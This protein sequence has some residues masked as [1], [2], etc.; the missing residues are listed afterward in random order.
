MASAQVY[1]P[2]KS[3][4]PMTTSLDDLMDR[5]PIEARRLLDRNI[6]ADISVKDAQTWL[7]FFTQGADPVAKGLST[8]LAHWL[9]L[10][11]KQPPT[12]EGLYPNAENW[13]GYTGYSRFAILGFARVAEFVKGVEAIEG[14]VP[15]EW[16][17]PWICLYSC[18]R[19]LENVPDDV[20]DVTQTAMP[21]S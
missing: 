5:L 1:I 2:N 10:A 9:N 3:F 20:E 6:Q 12:A 15:P 4:D 17:G 19:V 14:A 18:A 13:L 11:T 21:H 8:D 16:V 7:F